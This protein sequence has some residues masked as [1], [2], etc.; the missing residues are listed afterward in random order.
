MGKPLRYLLIGALTLF[1]LGTVYAAATAFWQDR[2]TLGIVTDYGANIRSVAPGSPAARDGIRPGDRV[3]LA[4]TPYR[5]RRYVTGVAASPPVGA[6]VSFAVEHAGITRS[7]SLVA[8]PHRLSSADRSVLFFTC[9]AS[10]VFIVV[11]VALI[12]LRPSPATWGFALYSFFTLPTAPSPFLLPIRHGKIALLFAYDVLQIIGFIGL[13]V[14]ALNFP[15]R[16]DVPWRRTVQRSLPAIFIVLS[17][18]IVY[19]DFANQLLGRG[20]NAENQIL[21][22]VLGLTSALALALAW[23]TYERIEPADRER[24]RWVVFGISA[25]LIATYIGNTIIYSAILPIAP[26]AWLLNLLAALNVLLPLSVAQA[27][28]RHRVLDIDFVISRAI[29]YAGFTAVL[30][31]T[32][33][34]LDWLFSEI[35]ADFRLSLIVNAAV[36]VGVAFAFDAL[37][38]RAEKAIE[39]ILFRKRRAA[40]K[41][42]EHLA[43]DLRRA[44]SADTVESAVIGEACGAFALASAA[45]FLRGGDGFTRRAAIGWES[46]DCLHIATSDAL[47]TTLRKNDAPTRLDA[48]QWDRPDLPRGTR[49][50]LVAVPLSY[51]FELQGIVFYGAHA[52]GSDIDSSELT[53]LARLVECA[54]MALDD[55]DAEQLRA[56]IEELKKRAR[57]N[58]LEPKS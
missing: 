32:F 46:S 58:V 39:S 47:A 9:L 21:Q 14:F 12:L 10:L 50:P 29:V 48:A 6:T 1:G 34:L 25:G 23:D 41:H 3:V 22:V 4:Q 17:V 52:D 33:G 27:V 40:R 20:A 45:L 36:S 57:P 37:Q 8:V 35:L 28:V 16:L 24:V 49:A 43:H 53:V 5:M 15:R 31:A 44:R 19:P 51:R 7:V 11:A 30:I 55:M 13:L 42:L 38:G 54:G 18:M 2:G 26:P 56:Q